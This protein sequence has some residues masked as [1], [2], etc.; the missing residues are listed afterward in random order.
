MGNSEKA[1]AKAATIYLI[2]SVPRL[3]L[4]WLSQKPGLLAVF[5]VAT[6]V[7]VVILGYILPCA[8]PPILEER[9]K[10]HDEKDDDG[11]GRGVTE[12]LPTTATKRQIVNVA[13]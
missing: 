13:D 4:V 3:R 10:D 1:S 11:N 2:N 5:V 8:H 12:L 9:D 7:V 6:S